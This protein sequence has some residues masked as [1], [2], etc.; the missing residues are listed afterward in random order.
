MAS[1]KKPKLTQDGQ[2]IKPQNASKPAPPATASQKTLMVL[3]ND[4]MKKVPGDAS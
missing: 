4:D 1:S 2:S 3:G